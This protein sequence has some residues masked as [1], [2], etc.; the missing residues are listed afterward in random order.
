MN[1]TLTTSELR[2]GNTALWKLAPAC[3]RYP[4]SNEETKGIFQS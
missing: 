1:R 3:S 2:E 4:A